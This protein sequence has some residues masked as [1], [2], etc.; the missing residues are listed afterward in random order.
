MV[1][2]IHNEAP[3]P[4]AVRIEKQDFSN[5]MILF[6]AAGAVAIGDVSGDGK[7][8][9]VVADQNDAFVS[10]LLN[11]TTGGLMMLVYALVK[12]PQMGWTDGTILAYFAIAIV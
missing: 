3:K 4:R 12:A 1:A 10:V 11:P 5:A 6:P 2:V 9:L 7:A 8:D